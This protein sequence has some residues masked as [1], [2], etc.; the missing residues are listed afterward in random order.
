MI[1]KS[2]P[3]IFNDVIGPIMRG[4]SSS[5]TAAAQ[6]IGAIIRQLN[7]A[8]FTKVLVEFDRT[9]ALAT[10]YLGQGSA[11]GLAGGLLGIEMTD[12]EIINYEKHLKN[13]NF[14][15]EYIITN[16]ENKNPNAYQ[17][18]VQYQDRENIHVLAISTGGG[19]FEIIEMNGFHVSIKGDFFENLMFITDITKEG[20]SKLKQILKA[21]LSDAIFEI[22][23]DKQGKVLLS[24]KSRDSLTNHLAEIK[25]L[26]KYISKHIEVSPVMPVISSFDTILPFTTESQML[27]MAE[28]ENISLSELAIRY[29]SARSG[30][31]ATSVKKKME[32]I[33]IIIYD[34]IQQGLDGTYYEDRILGSQSKLIKVAEQKGLIKKTINNSIIAFTSAIMEV[35]SSMGLIV[36]IP[37]AGSCGV[38][39]G[40][41]F[42][43]VANQKLDVESMVRAF[44]AAGI[45]GVFIAEKYTF[46]AEEGGCQVETGSGAAMAA[47]GLVE[48]NGGTAKQAMAAASMALQNELGLVCDPVAV[49]VEVPCLGKNI[50]AATNALNSYIMAIAGYNPMMPFNEVIDAM[51]SVGE[52][53]PS[54]LC[55]T[56][57]GGLAQTPTGK[58]L[59]KKFNPKPSK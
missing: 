6:R 35:K 18:S 39:G 38:V 52:A 21:N 4:P 27:D 1:K 28:K 22:L 3:S 10:T 16:I 2:S 14:S 58:C 56:G 19:M 5:H 50:M 29:E 55:C 26:D 46:S 15:I 36:A 9:S 47:A 17:I 34:S 49:R 11:L 40:A 54:S 13:S 43:S 51:K 20:L 24:I 8:V 25:G 59:H 44:L 41:L 30:L 23:K 48:M 57:L 37:T 45:T 7:K 32:E 33:V 42:G 31:D 53:L 12:P